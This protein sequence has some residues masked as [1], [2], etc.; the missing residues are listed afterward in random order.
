MHYKLA[1][2]RMMVHAMTGDFPR[3]VPASIVDLRPALE[4]CGN[5]HTPTLGIGERSRIIREYADDESNSETVTELQ[6]HVGGPGQPTPAGRAIHWHAD[7]AVRVEYIAMDADRETIPFV[8]VTNAQGQVKE[9]VVEGTTPEDLAKGQTRVMD[10]VDCHNAAMHRIAPTAEREVD[11][12]IAAGRISRSLPFVRREG[13]RLVKAEY[14]NE[15]AARAAID[16]GLR[17]VYKERGVVDGE[18]LER[19]IRALQGIYRR[20]VFPR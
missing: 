10:C 20:N 19:A 12:A 2:V 15:D 17:E 4:T 3:P 1:G 5:C 18:A 9:F 7:P 13:V 14:E 11:R 6:M 16:R 8:R